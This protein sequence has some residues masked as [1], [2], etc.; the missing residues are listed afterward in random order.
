MLLISMVKHGGEKERYKEEG[1]RGWKA[2]GQSRVTGRSTAP[3]IGA[4][5]MC[6]E[7]QMLND[8][9]DAAYYIY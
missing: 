1:L 3:M 9:D 6:P 8:G 7:L 2:S 5:L 4:D